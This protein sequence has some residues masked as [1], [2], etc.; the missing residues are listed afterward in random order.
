MLSFFPRGILDEILF[1]F[2]S[3][4]EGFPTYSYHFFHQ[5]N[6]ILVRLHVPD[7]FNQQPSLT[8]NRDHGRHYF[9]FIKKNNIIE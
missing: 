2:G 1:L 3:I 9:F 4:S 8:K 6:S 5:L 7:L